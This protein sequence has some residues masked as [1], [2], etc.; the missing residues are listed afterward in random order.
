MDKWEK[1]IELHHLFRR[2]QRP[3]PL[4]YLCSHLECSRPTFHR[5]RKFL[6]EV[7]GAPVILDKRYQGY[8][9]DPS[10]TNRFEL[11]GLW[12]TCRETEALLGFHQ[13]I[14]AL[15]HGL[16]GEVFAP[17]K[18]QLSRF[19]R[20]Q[21]LHEDHHE[22]PVKI[23]PVHSRKVDTTFFR[24]IA[25]AVIR[26]KT[27]VI[28]HEKLDGSPPVQRTVSPLLVVRYRDNWYLDAYCHLR[29]D[30]RTFSLDRI[31]SAALS[32]EKYHTVPKKE[33]K[34]F[35]AESYGIF[36]GPARHL[37]RIRFSGAA[38]EIV[39]REQWHP[40]QT[41]EWTSDHRYVLS[42]PYGDD[43]ELLMDILKW[44]DNAEVL[45]PVELRSRINSLLINALQNYSH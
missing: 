33:R 32:R 44:G 23:I 35:F 12:L 28:S 1:I 3:L 37:A 20:S 36:N 29:G 21:H 16:Y 25:D 2:N 6:V 26:K 40:R 4:E 34:R 17:V 24:T 8:R 10:V 22:T 39:S 30:L 27:L 31:A 18:K 9:Y 19:L 42:I 7:L 45:E 5:L 14:E 13:A 11:P 38:A 41:G 15:Q 43:R